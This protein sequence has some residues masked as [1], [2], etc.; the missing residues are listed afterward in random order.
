M[1]NSGPVNREKETI[2]IM[3]FQLFFGIF[4]LA[5]ELKLQLKAKTHYLSY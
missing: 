4:F 2:E 1:A 5:E 3:I